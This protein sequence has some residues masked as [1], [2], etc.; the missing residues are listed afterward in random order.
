MDSNTVPADVR[1]A[2]AN[3]PEDAERGEVSRFCQRQGIS[4]SVFYKI[5]RQA[6]E[7]GPVGATEPGSRRPLKSPRRADPKVIEHALAVRA[8]LVEQGLDAGPLSVHAKMKRQGLNPPSR[9]TL[10]RVFAAA[11]VS[12]PEPRKRPRAAN[13][14]FVYPAPNCC[15]QIDAFAWS[16]ADGTAVAIHQVID[17]HSRLALATLV[18]EGETAKA[19]VKVVST[20]VRRWGVPQRLLSD[21]GLAFNPTR[22]GFTGKLVDYL[23]DLGVKPITGKPDKPTTQGKNERFHQTLQ[24]WLNARPPARTISALQT[25]V[26][27]FDAYYD[28]ERVHQALDGKTPMEAWQATDPAPA[29]TPEPRLPQ[30][31]P[32]ARLTAN[33]AEAEPQ[34][35]SRAPLALHPS[36]G[37]IDLK[38][39]Q[40]GQVKVL[41]CLLYVATSRAGQTVHVIWNETTVEIFADDGEHIISY[42]RPATTGLY[43]G[44]RTPAGTPMKGAG[45]N[46]SAGS[47]GTA[48]RTV[49]KGGYIGVHANKFYAGYKRQTEQVTISWDTTVVTPT[50]ADGTT[51]AQYAKPDHRRGWHGPHRQVRST[52]S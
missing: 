45:H 12:R 33:S 50:D 19:A 40:N 48:T 14:R 31:P 42:P 4:R 1:W 27:E 26:N 7:L 35:K 49:S 37:I 5:R 46:P 24:K 32:S 41:S 36:V 3:W 20:A 11:G 22:R 44:P 21:N 2:I 16:L 9:A 6:R 43:Y 47:T 29:P 25:L 51:I 23:I 30:M 8:W 38:V 52:K 39:K 34:P 28:H 10:A 17:D 15:W 18:A 13:R